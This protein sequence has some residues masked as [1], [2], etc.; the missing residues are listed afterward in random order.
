IYWNAN[1]T[2]DKNGAASF[3]F[4]NSDGIGTYKA[5]IEGIDKDGNLGRYVYRYVVQ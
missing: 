1:V 3:E 5:I 4:F 2:T